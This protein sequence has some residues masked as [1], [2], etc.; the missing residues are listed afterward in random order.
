MAEIWKIWDAEL[1]YSATSLLETGGAKAGRRAGHDGAEPM[2]G[3]VCV[4][5]DAVAHMLIIPHS[6]W[7]WRA[8]EYAVDPDDL[9]TLLDVVLHEPWIP[10]PDDPLART[11]PTVVQV[12]QAT[13]GLPTCWT[14]GVS[15]ADRLAAHLARVQAVKTYRASLEP[16]RQQF[17]QDVLAY[18]GLDVTAPPDPLEPVK[19]MTRLDPARV[20]ARRL[21]V[22][23]YRSNQDVPTMPSYS[24]KPPATWMGRKPWAVARG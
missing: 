1:G 6:T 5:P 2:W 8:A 9:D 14:P 4:R 21:A 13:H 16:E 20:Q 24:L 18:V 19:A 11:D 15:D 10:A 3:I 12:L 23:W 7:E 17:R 22:D